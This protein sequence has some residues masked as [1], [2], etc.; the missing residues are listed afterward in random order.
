MPS[1]HDA[2][3]LREAGSILGVSHTRVAQLRDE[4]KLETDSNG[5][6]SL[7]QV[8]KYKLDTYGEEKD[9]PNMDAFEELQEARAKREK[10]AALSAELEYNE[11]KG[12]LVKL[13]DVIET[14]TACH[15]KFRQAYSVLPSRVAPQLV[16]KTLPEIER[17]LTDEINSMLNHLYA[18][19]FDNQTYH[20]NPQT[21]GT[22]D[23]EPMGRS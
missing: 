19:A 2:I 1:F 15:A 14:V 10:Y 6:V 5:K 23:G 9:D 11:Q 7:A 13:D 18:C 8:R 21:E 17:I 12:E 3:S 20:G 4:G 22:A 16:G